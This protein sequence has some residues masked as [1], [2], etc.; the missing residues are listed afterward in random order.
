M[1]GTLE[2]FSRPI[3]QL[4]QEPVEKGDRSCP[5]LPAKGRGQPAP[6][7]DAELDQAHEAA[8][9]LGCVGTRPPTRPVFDGESAQ[10]F[11]TKCIGQVPRETVGQFHCERSV[12]A[13]E[14]VQ[15]LRQS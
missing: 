15:L 6:H 11:G 9:A 1:I 10:G 7:L 5:A 2:T 3:P 12:N 13:R 4:R 8:V 14:M